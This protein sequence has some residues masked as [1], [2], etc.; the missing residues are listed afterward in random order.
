MYEASIIP[1]YRRGSLRPFTSAWK[2]DSF[3]YSHPLSHHL[4]GIPFMFYLPQVLLPGVDSSIHCVDIRLSVHI[5][6]PHNPL[7][8][9][10]AVGKELWGNKGGEP[11]SC[12][13]L[14]ALD[15]QTWD[16]AA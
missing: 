4:A 11:A 10:L 1:E 3:L 15:W 7:Q 6:N 9:Y 5:G 2:G 12:Q 14:R 13:S 8:I 16:T